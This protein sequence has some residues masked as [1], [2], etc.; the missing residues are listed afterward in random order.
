MTILRSDFFMIPQ[1]KNCFAFVI[2]EY[3]MHIL[4]QTAKDFRDFDVIQES[5]GT[6]NILA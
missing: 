1:H 5:L 3:G 2:T 6:D 4:Q